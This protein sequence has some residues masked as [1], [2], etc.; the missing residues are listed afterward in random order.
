MAANDVEFCRLLLT[1]ALNLDPDQDR[2]NVG[3]D[4]GQN[5]LALCRKLIFKKPTDDENTQNYRFM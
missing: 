1:C 4:L 5:F 2:Q 3:P